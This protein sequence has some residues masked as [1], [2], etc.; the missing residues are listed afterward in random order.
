MSTNKKL[1]QLASELPFYPKLNA[2]GKPMLVDCIVTG[3]DI[4]EVNPEA[5]G[6]DQKPLALH[7]KYRWKKLQPADHFTEMKKA[8]K[9]NGEQGVIDYCKKVHTYARMEKSRKAEREQPTQS[10]P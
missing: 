9:A 10:N 4:L 8:Y 3:A 1:R 5:K 7:A 2:S 6:K